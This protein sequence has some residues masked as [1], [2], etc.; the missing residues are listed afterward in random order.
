M[1]KAIAIMLAAML[2]VTVFAGCTKKGGESSAAPAGS[3][4][5]TSTESSSAS[6]ATVEEGKLIMVTE[7]GFAPYEYYEGQDVVGV[8]VDIAKE[9]AAAMGKELVV[10][11]IAFDS[12]IPEINAGKADIGAAGMSI[13]PERLEEV[14]FTIEYATSKQ[15]IVVKKDNTAIK[16]P[17]DI[18]GKKIA[19]QL[20]T[21]A[22]IVVTDE[23]PDSTIIQQKKY[24]AAA[25]DVKSGKAD[26]IVMDALPAQELVKANS[27][28]VILEKELF[29]DKYGMAVKKGNKALLDQVNT[30]LQKL[31]DEGKIEEFTLNHT[32]K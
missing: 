19:V 8:D 13:T 3:T 29:T 6:P 31:M 23:Y 1:K 11:D 24:L 15:V 14:D 12:I 30:I 10:K 16:N 17:E 4:D 9:I 32:S 18:K 7:A 22:D 5:A 28:L 21:V 26:C 20:G 27:E 2:A 25:E